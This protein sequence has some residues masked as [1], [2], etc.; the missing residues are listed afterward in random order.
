M[1]SAIVYDEPAITVSPL[2]HIMMRDG[3]TIA[4]RIYRFPRVR[5]YWI[6]E[7]ID[8]A[9]GLAMVDGVYP[10]DRAALRGLYAMIDATGIQSII[11]TTTTVH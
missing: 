3:M 9:G 7:V 8:Q 5:A 1:L 2:S 11:G 10:S 6:A 4:V